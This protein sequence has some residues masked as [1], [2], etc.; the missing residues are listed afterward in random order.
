M[1]QLKNLIIMLSGIIVIMLILF[2]TSVFISVFTPRESVNGT[3]YGSG[4]FGTI[5]IVVKENNNDVIQYYFNFTDEYVKETLEVKTFHLQFI[6]NKEFNISSDKSVYIKETDLLY[7]GIFRGPIT[8]PFT[9]LNIKV[10]SQNE[11]IKLKKVDS[12]NILSQSHRLE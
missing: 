7:R 3:Y 1:L 8:K 10:N 2:S 12:V 11:S 6:A 9:E 4:N 5:K